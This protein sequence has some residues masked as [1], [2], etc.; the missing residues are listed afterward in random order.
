M[1]RH[2]IWPFVSVFIVGCVFGYHLV[3]MAFKINPYGGVGVFIEGQTGRGVV[4][5]N[6]GQT[7]IDLGYG[8]FYEI[9]LEDATFSPG[10]E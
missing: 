3:E 1:C 7:D 6:M 4:N 10:L 8:Y 9:L 2:I 5:E